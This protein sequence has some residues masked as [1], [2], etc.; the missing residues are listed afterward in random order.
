MTGSS[1]FMSKGGSKGDKG[2]KG[3]KGKG[4][5]K[6]KGETKGC[7]G[8]GKGKEGKGQG[9]KSFKGFVAGKGQGQQVAGWKFEGKCWRCGTIGH[10]SET[11]RKV[12]SLEGTDWRYEEGTEEQLMALS[13]KVSTPK[14]VQLCSREHEG[15]VMEVR[16]KEITKTFLLV[17]SGAFAHCA[18]LNWA[19]QFPLLPVPDGMPTVV[20]ADGSEVTCF[21]SR[22][23]RY[24]RPDGRI[25]RSTFL[26]MS[27]HRPIL[28]VP[29]LAETGNFVHFDEQPRIEHSHGQSN[30]IREK[31][32]YYLPVSLLPSVGVTTRMQHKQALSLSAL[33]QGDEK[34]Q[35]SLFEWCCAQDSTLSS[36]F[37]SH[38]QRAYRLGLPSVNLLD[39]DQIAEV[40]AAIKQEIKEG[41]RVLLWAAQP[42][43]PWCRWQSVS[44]AEAEKRGKLEEFDSSLEL[45]RQQSR[46][47]LQNLLHVIRSV[48]KFGAISLAFE[49]PSTCT[50]WKEELVQDLSTW[51]PEVADC[52]GCAMNLTDESGEFIGKQWRVMTNLKALA[53]ELRRYRCAG[54]H[55]HLQC[56]GEKARR[57]AFY[58]AEM[59]TIVGRAVC[60]NKKLKDLMPLQRVE[61]PVR[62]EEEEDEEEV[63]PEHEEEERVPEVKVAKPLREPS[64]EEKRMHEATHLPFQAWCDTCVQGRGRDACHFQRE[65]REGEP[66]VLEMDYM[67]MRLDE[68]GPIATILVA[69]VNTHTFGL[70]VQV[71]FKGRE[72]GLTS[73]L[74]KFCTEAGLTGPLRIRTDSENA[75]QVVARDLML[76]RAPLQS[77]VEVT[78][79]GSSSSLGIAER[80]AESEGGM[81]R[82]L[83]LALERRW[84]RR[85][86]TASPYFPWAVLHGSWLMNRFQSHRKCGGKT[87]FE[88]VQHR[89]FREE[90]GAPV[91]A[92]KAYHTAIPKLAR[93][94]EPGVWLGK[95]YEGGVHM[96]GTSRRIVLSRTC[97]P[98]Q[99]EP[100]DRSLFDAMVWTPWVTQAQDM[101]KG[102]KRKAEPELEKEDEGEDT[103]AER[104]LKGTK[105][106]AESELEKEDEGEDTKEEHEGRREVEEGEEFLKAEGEGE[107]LG[108]R[109]AA[110]RSGLRP[111][112]TVV[113]D[114]P[115]NLGDCQINQGP[116][117][118]CGACEK[119]AA[120]RHH[121]VECKRRQ[122]E[123]KKA[124]E[125]EERA[126]SSWQ[127]AAIGEERKRKARSDDGLESSRRVRSKDKAEEPEEE[128]D[129]RGRKRKRD[130][131]EEEFPAQE[132]DLEE[133]RAEDLDPEK[134]KRGKE[135]ER[136]NLKR[137]ETFDRIK[138]QEARDKKMAIIKSRW[139]LTDCGEI[140]KARFIACEVAYGSREDVWAGTPTS[141]SQRLTMMLA[142]DRQWSLTTADV[143]TAFFER[144]DS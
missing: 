15:M 6:I 39:K 91:L 18:P 144:T 92:L 119:G 54:G 109:Q 1:G 14:V 130:E 103:Q 90:I 8:K 72:P 33:S 88:M 52:S 17:D 66:P 45:A 63:R 23:V 36:W 122:A 59:A 142:V 58:T 10:K 104:E 69:A 11:C 24:R 37:A 100:G 47:L 7:K 38:G 85:I 71:R 93:R 35:W 126:S 96:V 105:R 108:P 113:A 111:S 81:V 120:G 60:S 131:S 94:W 141:V 34:L 56:R 31:G 75:I 30:L 138:R 112:K 99:V 121:N 87:S 117:L 110:V 9:G 32:L 86:D 12:L 136:A 139:H 19:T 3:V 67:F 4:K 128:W 116:T 132:E 42:C 27:I 114:K 53:E 49:W 118:G 78:P 125:R 57:S 89:P 98:M 48:S 29:M 2:Q 16:K 79:V 74:L 101:P 41:R 127:G 50:G 107:K 143:K 84:G 64:A 28:S 82:V 73:R 70:G 95:T 21:G 25:G 76:A 5:G 61:E 22:D 102:A 43:T 80:F 44:C 134:V 26:V 97:K 106:K 20:T 40:I 135:D 129:S 65:I 133:L 68:K 140:V 123:W 77:Y 62:F 46:Q 115:Y 51:M 124:R 137:L 83:C 55:D 13:K